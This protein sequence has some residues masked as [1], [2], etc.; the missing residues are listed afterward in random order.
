MTAL[1]KQVLGV[2]LLEVVSSDL[3]ERDLRSNGEDRNPAALAV[4]QPVDQVQVPGT[5]RAG[6]N[7]QFTSQ[8]C[9]SSGSEGSCLLV[10]SVHPG[11]VTASTQSV[12]KT[13]ETITNNA[14]DALDPDLMQCLGNE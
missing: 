9:L 2:G 6:A 4:E 7:C 12:G 3:S 5:A 13:V 11:D 10:P 1:L 14:V 8:R